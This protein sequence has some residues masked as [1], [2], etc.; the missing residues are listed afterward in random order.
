MAQTTTITTSPRDV[1]GAQV[2]YFRADAPKVERLYRGKGDHAGVQGGIVEAY[3][4]WDR[5]GRDL[6]TRMHKTTVLDARANGLDSWDLEKNGFTFIPAAEPISDFK[7]QDLILR[8]YQPRVVEAVKKAA[9]TARRCF[10][11]SY[12][13]RSEDQPGGPSQVYSRLAHSDY[14]PGFEPLFR[15]MLAGR[16][17][18]PEEE[19]GNCGILVLGY[20]APIEQ[21]A[22]KDPLVVLDSSSLNLVK[23]TLLFTTIGDLGYKYDARQKDDP[24]RMPQ[25]AQDAPA[26][27]PLYNP[28][29]RWVYCPDMSPEE[30]V[31]FKQFDYRK[32]TST[33]VSFHHSM[34]DNFHN[35]WKDCPGRRSI[36][37]RLILTFDEDGEIPAVPSLSSNL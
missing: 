16:Y 22:Y 11:M 26:I 34:P 30:A 5:E 9:K 15:K 23:D 21:P 36:E 31:V 27:G 32:S 4:G 28:Q 13:R 37:V 2:R 25:A 10:W 33:K 7:D 8:D 29:H 24:K 12:V 17:G 14:G 35:A 19:A 1:L 18:V 20:W 6:R 3:G